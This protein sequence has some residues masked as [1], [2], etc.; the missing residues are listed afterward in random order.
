MTH[1]PVDLLRKRADAAAERD[2]VATDA[3]DI[4]ATAGPRTEPNPPPERPTPLSRPAP[5]GV[6]EPQVEL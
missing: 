3:S 2:H 6:G 4:H 5:P 1:V